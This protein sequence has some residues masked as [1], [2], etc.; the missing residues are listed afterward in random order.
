M[1]TRARKGARIVLRAMSARVRSTCARA[2][3]RSARALSSSIAEAAPREVMRSTRSRLV[4]GETRLRFLRAKL[5][6]LHRDVE[7]DEHGARA[8]RPDQAAGRR[9]APFRRTSLRSVIERGASTV[10][11]AEADLLMRSGGRNGGGDG[12]GRLGLIGRR[13]LGAAEAGVLPRAEEEGGADH[14]SEKHE[15]SAD[16]ARG[17]GAVE[18]LMVG[19]PRLVQW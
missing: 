4:C 2:T 19:S 13:G 6:G 7:G 11:I 14:E 5:G 15:R 1:P 16:R 12:L 9:S 10:P 18:R 3:S 17:F 8:R